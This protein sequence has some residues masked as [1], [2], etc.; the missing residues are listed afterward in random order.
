MQ[1]EQKQKTTAAMRECAPEERQ[2]E[3]GERSGGPAPGAC[4]RS[5]AHAP[6]RSARP[7]SARRAEREPGAMRTEI[8][9]EEIGDLT[10]SGLWPSD[11]AGLVAGLRLPKG[12]NKPNKH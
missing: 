5:S 4:K 6:E 3:L 2:P 11:H 12:L 1:Q 8:V 10:P 9:G 7:S